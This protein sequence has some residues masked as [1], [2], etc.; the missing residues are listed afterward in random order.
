MEPNRDVRL[1]LE[2]GIEDEVVGLVVVEG[3]G[4]ERVVPF[5]LLLFSKLYGVSTHLV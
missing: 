3:V 4:E 1:C 5:L 2:T